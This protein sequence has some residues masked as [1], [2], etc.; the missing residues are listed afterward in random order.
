MTISTEASTSQIYTGTGLVTTYAYPFK[1]FED[2]ELIV[3]M[4]PVV[5]GV[6]GTQVTL[7]LNTDY[8]VTGAGNAAGGNVVLSSELAL[9]YSLVAYRDMDY[10]QEIDLT[11]QEAVF[12]EQ[13]E[14]GLDIVTMLTQQLNEKVERC[15][16]KEPT[17][18]SEVPT[19]TEILAAADSAANS[20][21]AA[22]ASAA[23]VQQS[24]KS[25]VAVATTANITLSGEQTLDGVLTSASR[26]LVRA[27]TDQSENGVYLSGSGAWT[28]TE[29][30]DTATE[31]NGCIVPVSGGTLYADTI[32]TQ[33]STI[34]TIDTDNVTFGRKDNGYVALT[35][36]DI[37]GGTDIGA[38][39]TG[40]MLF[41]VDKDGSGTNVKCSGSRVLSYIK[42]DPDFTSKSVDWDAKNLLIDVASNTTVSL[43]VDSIKFVSNTGTSVIKYDISDAWDITTDLM[44]GTSE[45]ASHWYAC[46]RDSDAVM[47]MVPDLTGTADA[48]VANSLS[49]STAT[50]Q[51]DLVQV[52]DEI[53]NLTD[54]TK[55]Y[56]KAVSSETV[57]TCKDADGNDYDLFPAG[58]EDFMIKMLSPVGLGNHKARIGA[59]YNNGSS[60]LYNSTY[61]QIQEKKAYIG[62]V[63][64]ADFDVSS[65][66]A[67]VAL[68]RARAYVTQI[69]DWTGMGAWIIDCKVDYT[70]A[71]ASR[72]QVTM[73]MTGVVFKN[74]GTF[75]QSTFGCSTAAAGIRNC[76]AIYNTGNVFLE[77]ASAST[78]EYLLSLDGIE[79]DKKPTFHT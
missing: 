76:Y 7:V 64:G 2:S 63:S 75:R 66:P 20:A 13:L 22:A 25:V 68:D 32:W 15:I 73:T 52:D 11:N 5:S 49:V 35:A 21:A 56:V 70:V 53:Y 26:V 48:D 78:T 29:D 46:W 28:R 60:N 8:T 77:H 16:Y 9:N 47:K 50:F 24:W 67:V 44:S 61:T 55:G 41:A 12:L 27:Q 65:S 30:A 38:A 14:N 34:V 74:I 17:D 51:T 54:L 1:I 45:K 18:G 39:L 42:T 33:E 62:A 40:D 37:D 3:D 31:L 59:A 72:S 4:L 23:S 79:C 6:T 71:T 36:L 58:T 57:I 19:Y 43:T 10:L 69:N